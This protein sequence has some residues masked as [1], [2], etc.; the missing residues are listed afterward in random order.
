MASPALFR[1]IFNVPES[2]VAAC[3]TA[4]FAAGAGRNEQP[5][6]DKNSGTTPGS[7]H[8]TERCWTALGTGQFRPGDAAR[9]HLGAVGVLEQVPEVRVEAPCCGEEVVRRAVEALKRWVLVFFPPCSGPTKLSDRWPAL[10][11]GYNCGSL[12]CWM[13]WYFLLPIDTS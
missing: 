5:P 2:H 11:Y 7:T 1:L 9:P 4:I 10:V 8:Y 6:D 12:I 3:K 13:G